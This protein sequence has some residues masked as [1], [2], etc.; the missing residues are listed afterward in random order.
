MKMMPISLPLL[1]VAALALGQAGVAQTKLLDVLQDENARDA[2]FWIYNDLAA[3]RA[4]AKRTDKP[5][6]VTFRCVPCAD[7]KG[8]DAEVA[9]NNQR[10]KHLTQEAFVA[11]RQV[12]MK[13]VDL[14]Q[15]QFDYDLNWA[16]MFINADGT[17]YAR[18]GTQSAK[19]ADAYNSIES[20]EKTMRRVLALH[21]NYPAN[22]VTLAGKLGKPKPYKTALQMPGMK[23]RSKLAGSTARNNCVHCH[24]IHDAEHEQLH[25]AGRLT[26]DA[27][28]RYPLPDNLGLQ[29]DPGDGRIVTAVKAN[30][31]ADKVGLRPGDVLTHA[32]GQALTS[33]ADL[34][35]VLHNL[36]NTQASVTLKATRGERAIEK[37]LAMR[38]GWK[39]TDISWRGSLWS[40]KPV[41]ATWCAPMKE[42]QVKLLRLAKGVKPLEVRWINTGRPE[43]RNAKRAGLRQ[44]DIIIGMEGKPLRMRSEHFNMHVK[45]NYKVGD[46]LPLTLLRKG[47]RIHFD[48]PLT[49]GD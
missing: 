40:I 30:S 43:G 5:L 24:N 41:L 48:W 10:I 4:E 8:F 15:F 1:A 49:D 6:F 34:Q 3:A 29:L 33:I 38:A 39:K 45:L 2:D 11:V 32:D 16:A 37:K 18:Y 46:K 42:K 44:G 17:V 13:G 20:L 26:H 14:S 31:P 9:K 36:P 47:K 28:W 19:G 27:L 22:K 23:H 7:C 35:W 12:E 25:D 21:K